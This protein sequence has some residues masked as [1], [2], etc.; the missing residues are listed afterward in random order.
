MILFICLWNGIR[1]A[2]FDIAAT[3]FFLVSLYSTPVV[4]NNAIC[5]VSMCLVCFIGVS[6]FAII[7]A[8][9][10][11]SPFV[12]YKVLLGLI[13]NMISLWEYSHECYI[14]FMCCVTCRV[15]VY[16]SKHIVHFILF[17]MNIYITFV[18]LFINFFYSVDD[19]CKD[20]NSK[21]RCR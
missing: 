4:P 7:N 5:V 9:M 14:V 17:I 8:P 11:S 16:K 10:L 20:E 19:L 1:N 15:R 12:Q 13:A 3:P 6:T 18:S 21:L 2:N